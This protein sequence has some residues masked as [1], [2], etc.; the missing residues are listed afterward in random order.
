MS[1][2]EFMKQLEILL[3]DVSEEEKQE[4]LSYYRSYFEDAGVENEE[5]ILKELESPEKVAATI[6]SDLGI[7]N[8][9]DRGEYTESG[10]HDNRFES[11]QEVG[12][13]DGKYQQADSQNDR[14]Y[15]QT[16]TWN[17]SYNQ[18]NDGWS[19]GGNAQTDSR[20]HSYHQ[21]TDSR[22]AYG[23]NQT[24]KIILIIVVAIATAPVWGSIIGLI[25]GILGTIFGVV[26]AI[27]CADLA[28]YVAGGVLFGIGIGQLAVGSLATG[29]ALVGAGLLVIAI[30]VLMTILCVWVLGKAVP[31]ICNVIRRLWRS[32]FHRKEQAV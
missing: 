18:Q 13:C 24:L 26:V 21:Q 30:A 5:R 29:L 1:R 19:T 16:D 25:L 10:F 4:A 27:V 15:Q 22:S 20:N 31:W 3:T 28:L 6:K 14:K 12:V 2:E 23:E 11:R 17:S 8:I 9:G 7:E 32:I